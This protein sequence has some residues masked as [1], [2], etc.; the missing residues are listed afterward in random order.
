M[1]KCKALE[2]ALNNKLLSSHEHLKKGVFSPPPSVSVCISVCMYVM[3]FC[4][5]MK[6]VIVIMYTSRL[7]CQLVQFSLVF[8]QGLIDTSLYTLH[9]LVATARSILIVV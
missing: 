5:K 3:Q 2:T 8:S 6:L 1:G 9:I 4:S 7:L